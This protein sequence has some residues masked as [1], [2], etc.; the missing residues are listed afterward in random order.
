MSSTYTSTTFGG[1][2]A[3]R[4][5]VAA[6]S[7]RRVVRSMELVRGGRASVSPPHGAKSSAARH[8]PVEVAEEVRLVRPLV[9]VERL[10]PGRRR[11][12]PVGLLLQLLQ[13]GDERI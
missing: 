1:R 6:S 11:V 2:A 3:A 5:G 9:K 8:H 10:P 7:A 12:E 4:S 13:G